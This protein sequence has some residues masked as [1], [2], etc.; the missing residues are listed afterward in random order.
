M[1]NGLI[2]GKV[3]GDPEQRTGKGETTFVVLKLKA[4]AGD[5]ETYLVNV[6]GFD[7]VVCQDMMALR[8]GDAVALNGSLTPKI[9]TDKQGNSRPVLDLVAQGVL[10][11]PIPSRHL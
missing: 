3:F 7:R 4:Q 6:I 9:W 1:M 5:G 2:S 11:V 10:T 8:D